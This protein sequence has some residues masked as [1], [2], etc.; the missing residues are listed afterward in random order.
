MAIS[1]PRD[2]NRVPTIMGTLDSDGVTPTLILVNPVNHCLKVS[3]GTTGSTVSATTAQ[4]DAN[5]VPVLWGVSSADGVT[6][7]Y[8]AVDSTGKILIQTT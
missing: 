5:R 8:I 2:S 6:P 1:A 7:T 3:D 4:R